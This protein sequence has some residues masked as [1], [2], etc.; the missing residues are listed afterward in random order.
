MEYTP[1]EGFVGGAWIPP[2]WNCVAGTMVH[3]HPRG[4]CVSDQDVMVAAK[5]GLF[6]TCVVRKDNLITVISAPHGWPNVQDLM[7]QFELATIES[8]RIAMKASLPSINAIEAHADRIMPS[9]LK[10]RIESMGVSV[11]EVE[12]LQ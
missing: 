7:H 8:V 1:I 5:L 12:A 9:L 4:T 6:Q 3:N 2:E 11:E 10:S